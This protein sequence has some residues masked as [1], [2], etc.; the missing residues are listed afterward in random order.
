MACGSTV[1]VWPTRDRAS[2]WTLRDPGRCTG[3]NVIP[4][5]SQNL[6]S[7]MIRRVSLNY[8]V[9]PS[10]VMYDTTT[11]LSY[12]RRTTRDLSWGRKPVTVRSFW[13][14][15]Q[16]WAKAKPPC[17]HKG[18]HVNQHA[19]HSMEISS[20][21]HWTGSPM[22]QHSL[23]FDPHLGQGCHSVGAHVELRA[24]KFELLAGT[25]SDL[26]KLITQPRYW[27][28]RSTSPLKNRAW[29]RSSWTFN[30]KLLYKKFRR[31]RSETCVLE[32]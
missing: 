11:A 19:Q 12:I 10:L 25:K 24:D 15:P 3:T 28:T 16:D 5:W 6:R 14:P 30:W 29:R 22:V 4:F 23:D 17:G 8:L 18:G 27:S 13:R 20:C 32:H 26:L 21:N 31:P 2:A 7:W 9:L 1:R